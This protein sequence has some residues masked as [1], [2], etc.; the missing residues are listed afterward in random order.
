MQFEKEYASDGSLDDE[1][2][3]NASDISADVE[4]PLLNAREDF[5]VVMN[6]FLQ[7]E[8]VGNKLAP[9]LEG[10]TP[11][12]KLDTIRKALAVDDDVAKR[13]ALLD[14]AYV[15]DTRVPMPVDIDAEKER[16]DCETILSETFGW[17]II[18]IALWCQ[19][20]T[21]DF[22][23]L[24]T[25]SNLENHPRFLRLKQKPPTKRIVLDRKTGLPSIVENANPTPGPQ[26]HEADSEEDGDRRELLESFSDLALSILVAARVT[27]TRSKGESKEEKKSRK[28]AVKE[29]RQQRRTEKKGNKDSFALERKNIGR[30]MTTREK[31]GIRKL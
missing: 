18:F 16:W 21:D 20:D 2:L 6:E 17:P 31:A 27:V 5:D 14:R 15:D 29:E 11:T 12:D 13:Q 3:E 8:L 24:A 26:N 30:V 28:K 19:T 4:P 9:S 10:D 22:T 25:Y 1:E 7:L 23:A